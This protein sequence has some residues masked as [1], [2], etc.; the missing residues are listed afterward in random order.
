MPNCSHSRASQSRKPWATVAQ[1]G[2]VHWFAGNLYEAMVDMPQLLVDAQS[3]REPGLLAVGSPVRYY[4]IAAPVTLAATVATLI[5]SWRSGGDRSAII[6]AAAGTA[7]AAALTGYLIKKVNVQLLRNETLPG[8]TEQ[9]R[10]V[11]TWHQVN[12][13]RLLLVAVAAGA[14][15]RAVAFP[16]GSR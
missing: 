5:D 8:A 10:L 11:S 4:A 1:L 6:T 7:S 3:N 12:L 2:H 15:G 13:V 14:L 9:R 16:V